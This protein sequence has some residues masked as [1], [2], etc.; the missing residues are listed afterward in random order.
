MKLSDKKIKEGQLFPT[1]YYGY[2]HTLYYEMFEVWLPIPF[3]FLNRWWR[4]VKYIWHR[5]RGNKPE[6]DKR[7]RNII[8]YYE[9]RAFQNGVDHGY[10]RGIRHSAILFEES[11]KKDNHGKN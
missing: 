5:F 3:N 10:E 11:I 4:S 7:I 8:N 6:T 9:Q 1:W 2:S